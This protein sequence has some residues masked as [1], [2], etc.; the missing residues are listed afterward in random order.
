V[1]GASDSDATTVKYRPWTRRPVWNTRWNSP[2]RRTLRVGGNPR[3][4]MRT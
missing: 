2:R 1:A 3:G 4:R